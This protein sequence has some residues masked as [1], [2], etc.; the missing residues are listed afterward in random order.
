MLKNL[1]NIILI[2]IFIAIIEY[3]LGWQKLLSPWHAINFLNIVWAII[4]I[5][6]TYI[7][8]SARLYFYF[9]DYTRD[10]FILCLKLIIQHNF[11][12]NFM[13]MRTGEVTFPLLLK[14]FFNISLMR[15]T[16]TLFWFRILDLY[17]IGL[18]SLFLYFVLFQNAFSI[19]MLL[20]ALPIPWLI[21]FAVNKFKNHFNQQSANKIQQILHKIAQGLPNSRADFWQAYLWTII[22]WG[23]KIA[24]LAWFLSFFGQAS[25]MARWLGAVGGDMTSILPIH[26]VAGIGSYEA[27]VV[28]VLAL[29]EI[30]MEV[31]MVM[32][33]NVHL[34][35]LSATVISGIISLF[36]GKKHT[37]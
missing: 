3:W 5:I 14:Q 10:K 36:L 16:G 30:D 25:F 21:I 27:G 13:P 28:F 1:L 7:V 34:L 26:N 23:F 20:F 9:I 35:L 22:N 32:A 11:A 37:G 31:A 29:F 17:I 2:V 6:L 15:A 18:L 4:L 19:I 8:R 33:V 24:I 12:N